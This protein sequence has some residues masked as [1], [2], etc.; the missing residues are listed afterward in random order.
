MNKF[1]NFNHD[2]IYLLCKK[3]K[4]NS[5]L[6]YDSHHDQIF[7]KTCEQLYMKQGIY[8]YKLSLKKKITLTSNQFNIFNL[9]RWRILKNDT[10]K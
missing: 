4:D 2:E 6:I 5:E 8:I 1:K 9:K 3:C 7:C 10:K